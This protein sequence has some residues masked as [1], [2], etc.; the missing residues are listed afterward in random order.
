MTEDGGRIRPDSLAGTSLDPDMFLG[1]STEAGKRLESEAGDWDYF[2]SD[3]R[4]MSLVDYIAAIEAEAV[5]AHARQ[6]R[7][8]VEG[9]PNVECV[10]LDCSH[11]DLSVSQREHPWL[12]RAAV[13]R[14]IE[15]GSL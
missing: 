4:G 1:P 6:I 3:D 11:D 10:D 14:I 15:V 9:L 8:A 7:V 13:L 12:D 2:G 5:S